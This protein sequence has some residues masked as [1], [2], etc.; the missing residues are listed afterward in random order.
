MRGLP[1]PALCKIGVFT[2]TLL[3]EPKRQR[4][5]YL[6]QR[7]GVIR[8]IKGFFQRPTKGFG[9][10]QRDLLRKHALIQ[11]IVHFYLVGEAVY[12]IRFLM[13]TQMARNTERVE[14]AEVTLRH[15]ETSIH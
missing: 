14:Q 13:P 2:L 8:Q 15:A 7:A 1:L 6:W 9:M 3:A 5:R 12:R 11:R 4:Y 10:F